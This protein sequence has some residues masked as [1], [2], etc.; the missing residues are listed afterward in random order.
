MIQLLEAEQ[1][2]EQA[3]SSQVI[4]VRSPGEYLQGHV[5]KALNIPLFN[6]EERA[7]IGTLYKESGRE[8]AILKGLD[9]VGPKLS[10]ILKTLGSKTREKD[11]LIHCWRGGMRS[12]NMAWLFSQTGYR[13]SVLIGGYKAYRKH[14]RTCFSRPARIFVLGGLT[15]SGKTDILHALEDQHEQ[16][17][18]LEKEACHKGSVFGAFGQQS[19]PT[20]EQFENNLFERWSAFDPEKPVWIEDESRSIGNVNIPEPL[21]Q[22]ITNPEVMIRIDCPKETRIKRL[23]QEYSGVQK[24][25]LKTAL[26]KLSEKLGDRLKKADSAL[27][28]GNYGE[29]A[30]I[31]LEYY[32]K[33]YAHS[34]SKRPF[35]NIHSIPILGDD[36]ATTALIILGYMESFQPS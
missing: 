18:D 20:T 25:D 8:A 21:F 33:T 26:K 11:I 7:I 19:Q 23:I 5:P 34:I 31:V 10:S 6:D 16:V 17:L 14:I 28:E 9:L 36:A 3:K 13:V 22:Q 24:D 4:D 1:F 29:M 15:G 30:D 2:L 32:D 12:E 35:L 27:S